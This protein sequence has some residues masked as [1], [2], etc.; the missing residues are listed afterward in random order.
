MPVSGVR[1]SWAKAASAASTIPGS[2][3]LAGFTPLP[4]LSAGFFAD[5]AA[6]FFAGRLFAGRPLRVGRDFAAMI[7]RPRMEPA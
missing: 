1:T 3:D 2:F 4:R 7:L 5:L 6:R